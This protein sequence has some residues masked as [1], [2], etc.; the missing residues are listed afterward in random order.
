MN[1]NNR[2]EIMNKRVEKRFPVRFVFLF[3]MVLLYVVVFFLNRTFFYQVFFNFLSLF[4]SIYLIILFV[5]FVMFMVNLFLKDEFI[6]KHLGEGSGLKGWVW[7]LITGILVPS[8]PYVVFPLLSDMRNKGMKVSL[9]VA[10]LYARNLQIIFL[11]VLSFYF[12]FWFAVVVSVY[13]FVFSILSGIVVEKF[14]S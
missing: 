5:F 13:V 14:L 10:F 3:M 7:A 1:S 8:P 2:K 9:I 6:K 4:S 12:G 11:P